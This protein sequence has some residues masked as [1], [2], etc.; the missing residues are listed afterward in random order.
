MQ[1]P[2]SRA[3]ARRARNR[4]GLASQRRTHLMVGLK[5][6]VAAL[7]QPFA[8]ANRDAGRVHRCMLGPYAFG[9]ICTWLQPLNPFA[10]VVERTN[11][12]R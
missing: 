6:R 1:T 9:G 10:Q 11:G 2:R 7:S 3:V 12:D 5:R 8:D 4:G